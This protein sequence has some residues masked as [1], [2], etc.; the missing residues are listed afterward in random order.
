[1]TPTPPI[2][3]SALPDAHTVGSSFVANAP[4][5]PFVFSDDAV[6]LRN[7]PVMP[8]AEQWRRAVAEILRLREL[9]AIE[10]DT[11]TAV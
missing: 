11:E 8:T 6:D 5:T 4:I 1:M 2:P 10:R 3:S 7:P 9:L